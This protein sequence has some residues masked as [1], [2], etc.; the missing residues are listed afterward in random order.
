MLSRLLGQLVRVVEVEVGDVR[1][2]DV[3]VLGR[4]NCLVWKDREE[5]GWLLRWLR[6][7]HH[8]LSLSGWRF[9]IGLVGE[10]GSE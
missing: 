1:V 3:V 5:F 10:F 8:V 4:R 7:D 9:A 2:V 6:E